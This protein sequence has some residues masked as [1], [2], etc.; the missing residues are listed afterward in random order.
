MIL[1]LICG[2][3]AM[4]GT[5]LAFAAGVG[6]VRFPDVYSRMHAATKAGT[7][8]AGLVLLAVMVQAWAQID[9][10]LRALAGIV[11]LILSAPVGAHVLGRAAYAAGVPLWKGSER[12][13]LKGRYSELDEEPAGA[14]LDPKAFE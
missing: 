1:D 8:G 2:V 9:V 12:D 14:G 3:L 4:L 6:M 7:L 11:F 10:V 13:D 5:G